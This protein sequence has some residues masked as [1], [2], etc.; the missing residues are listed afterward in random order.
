M[1]MPCEVTCPKCGSDSVL[2][3]YRARGEEWQAKE[4]RGYPSKFAGNYRSY[5]MTSN[6]EHIEHTCQTCWHEWQT[7]PLQ[8]VRAKPVGQCTVEPEPQVK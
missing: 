4:M 6:R 8:K 1:T 5:C 2:R 7:R 3:R